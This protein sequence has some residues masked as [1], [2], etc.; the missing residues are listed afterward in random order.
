[1]AP[2][3]YCLCTDCNCTATIL[4]SDPTVRAKHRHPVS[5]PAAISSHLGEGGGQAGGAAVIPPGTGIIELCYLHWTLAFQ[6]T[7]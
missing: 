6:K 5:R 4:I 3:L 1:M 2:V 7:N